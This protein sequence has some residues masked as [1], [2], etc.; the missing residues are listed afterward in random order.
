MILTELVMQNWKDPS[1][2]IKWIVGALIM[3]GV[4]ISFIFILTRAYISKMRA[5]LIKKTARQIQ[6]KEELITTSITIQEK[7]RIRIAADIHDELIAQL[8]RLKLTNENQIMDT[9]ISDSIITA[10]KISHDLYPPLLEESNL[11]DLFEIFLSPLYKS[12]HIDFY[13]VHKQH[14][15]LPKE[16][17][18]HIY[19]I[20]Q[21]IITNIIKHSQSTTIA[22]YV[23]ASLQSFSLLIKDEGTG[24]PKHI[25]NGLGLKNIDLRAQQIKA[26]YKFSSNRP[27]GTK[28]LLKYNR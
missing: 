10:R 3:V 21:E 16:T 2:P 28:F 12:I 11:S 5:E 27:K 8:Y 1:T 18:I 26:T 6:H 23:R 15:T 19:R 22:I 17:K 20:F 24:I 9:Y 7:E 25:K 14:I 4:L 13:H